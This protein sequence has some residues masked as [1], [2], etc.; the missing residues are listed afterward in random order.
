MVQHGSPTR[1]NRM[2]FG[3]VSQFKILFAVNVP[4]YFLCLLRGL[5]HSPRHHCTPSPSRLCLFS[6]ATQPKFWHGYREHKRSEYLSLCSSDGER[7]K[8]QH[9][10]CLADCWSGYIAWTCSS[11]YFHWLNSIQCKKHGSVVI[12]SVVC[13]LGRQNEPEAH[14]NAMLW[15][16]CD[17]RAVFSQ[18]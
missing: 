5:C 3:P 8:K 18:V 17:D 15:E 4:C 7:R 12:R 9:T 2:L 16:T 1:G 6:S 13:V 10:Y 14:A 11:Y